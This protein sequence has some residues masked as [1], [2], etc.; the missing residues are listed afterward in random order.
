VT[1][2]FGNDTLQQ[3]GRAAAGLRLTDLPAE[4]LQRAK[5]RVLDT[6][7][8]LV[9]GYHDGISSEIR[10]YVQAQG[11][12]AEATLLPRGEKTTAALAGLAHAAYIFGLELS[13]AA[14]RGTVHPGSEIVSIALAV[15]ERERLSGAAII[16][17]L[18]AG[19]EIEIRF[20]RALHPSAFYKG[21]STIGLLGILGPTVTS[22]HLL[23]LDAE[24]MANAIGIALHLAPATTGRAN[25]PGSVKWLVGGHACATGLLAAEMARRGTTG[26]R[27]VDAWLKVISDDA[28]PQRLLEG[29]DAD[30]RFTQWELLSGVVTKYYAAPGPI[31][32]P[33]EAMFMLLEKHA[34]RADDIERIDADCTRRTAIFSQPNPSDE[35]E[36]RGSLPHCLALAV[37][38]RD[39][40]L[41]LGPGYRE[42]MIQDPAIRAMAAKVRITANEAYESQYPARSLARITL[43]LRDGKS[44]SLEAD[45]SEIRRYLEP[46]D[47]DIE[48]K[49]RLIA[50]PVLG[51]QKTKRIVDIAFGLER[52]GD[53]R[54]LMQAMQAT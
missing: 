25:Q 18:V 10:D 27:A 8:C 51:E 19:Y 38:K 1:R 6:L 42:P 52:A 48:A 22:G 33:I 24:R 46:T 28:H 37:C 54:E 30:G 5:Q 43:H 11:G 13:D 41:L 14:P 53:T 49:F 44:V 4:G 9:M 20:G 35:L 36:A 7:G 31:A 26:S 2:D 45:R 40:A 21:W 17:A 32:T 12:R 23:G 16:P 15:A 47:A 3:L 29:I 34:I 50:Q 39:P